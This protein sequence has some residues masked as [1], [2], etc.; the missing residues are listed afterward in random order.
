[1]KENL[2][3]IKSRYYKTNDKYKTCKINL[4]HEKE[5]VE[6]LHKDT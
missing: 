2:Q 5:N 3:D 4:L 6:K 1:M